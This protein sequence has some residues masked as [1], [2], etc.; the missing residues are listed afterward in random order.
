M[1]LYAAGILAILN[2]ALAVSA[3]T[4]PA[5]RATVC[6][7]HAELCE[8]S[9]GA[10]TYVGTHDSYAIGAAS[11]LAVNQDQDITTQLNDGVRMLQMQAHNQNNVIRLCH[12]TCVLLDGGTL[13]TYLTT[14]KSWLDANPNEVLSLLIVNID[15]MPASAYGAVFTKVGLDAVSY[16]PPSTPLAATAWPTLGAMIDSGKRLVTFLDNQADTAAV[17]YLLDEFTNVWETQFNVIDVAKFDCSVNRT[18]G[19]TGTQMFLVNHFLD[20]VLLGQPVP[21]VE[22]LN[23]TNAASGAGSL[24][25]HVQTCRDNQGRAPNFLLVD[26]YEY[27]AGSV[28]EVAAGIN[29]VTYAPTTPIATPR[30]ANATSGTG[31]SN[32]TG[33]NTTKGGNGA[34]SAFSGNVIGSLVAGIAFACSALVL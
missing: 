1:K 17:P 6:N 27:G 5:K 34:A 8:R 19:D 33:G 22:Q 20:K 30:S 15:N 7:G 29:G 10:V 31:A 11:N 12:S 14:V 9:F 32:T 13:E 4:T 25:A 18:K 2:A 28:F 21:F 24:G 3:T 26:F 23:V 16:A